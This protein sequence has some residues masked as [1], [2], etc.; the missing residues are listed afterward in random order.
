[1]QTILPLV[2]KYGAAV[3]ALTMDEKGIP[4]TAQGAICRG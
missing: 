3:V 4:L 2:K 1:M